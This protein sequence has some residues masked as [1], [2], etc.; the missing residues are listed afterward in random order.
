[1]FLTTLEQP[2]FTVKGGCEP[3]PRKSL[4]AVDCSS[5]HVIGE[6]SSGLDYYNYLV[7]CHKSRQVVVVGNNKG[8][9]GLAVF[10]VPD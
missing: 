3:K 4:V 9:G 5:G 10:S 1:M 6:L 8:P 2:K 7:H